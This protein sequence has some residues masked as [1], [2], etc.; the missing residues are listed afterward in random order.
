M[1]FQLRELELELEE[2]RKQRSAAV[3]ARKK[4][5]SENNDMLAQVDSANK[6][7]DDALKQLKRLQVSST[8]EGLGIGTF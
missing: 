5:E 4:V 1:T 8:H 7:R 2:E 3:N 6:V